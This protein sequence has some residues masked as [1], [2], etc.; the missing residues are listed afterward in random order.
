MLDSRALVEFIVKDV[1]ATLVIEIFPTTPPVVCREWK[2]LVLAV[3]EVLATVTDP[4]ERVEIPIRQF[5]P[6]LI[7]WPLPESAALMF[8]AK[9]AFSEESKE[10]A[11]A[12]PS[13]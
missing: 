8:A 13:L 11:S 10:I 5:D 7:L 9:L 1:P 6:S 4:K 12:I 3:T 2:I